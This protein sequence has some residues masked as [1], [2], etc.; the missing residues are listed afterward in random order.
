MS[1]G[2]KG[3]DEDEKDRKANG[4]EQKRVAF[5]LIDSR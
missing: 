3:L 1:V 2:E 5:C 4:D